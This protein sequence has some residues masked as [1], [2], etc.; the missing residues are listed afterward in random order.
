MNNRRIILLASAAFICAP[1]ITFGQLARKVHRIGFLAAGAP[2]GAY[3]AQLL[4][5]FRAGMRELGYV[6]GQTFA[7][8]A[9]Y[10][11]GHFERFPAL[12]AELVQMKVD[13]LVTAGGT[14]AVRAAQEA[15]RAIPIVAGSI[16]DPVASGLVASLARPGGNITGLTNFQIDLGPKQLELLATAVP[17]L[18]RIAVLVNPD[19]AIT[20]A[21]ANNIASAARKLGAE[22]QQA[23]AR[24]AEE[25]DK[26]FA[27]I[28]SER[29]GACIIASDTFINTEFRR[30]AGLAAKNRLPCIGPYREYAEA[31]GLMSYGQNVIESYRR[32][33]S[34]VDKILKG[35]K[36]GDLPIEQP[37]RLDLVINLKTAKALGIT[38]PNSILVRA[39]KVIE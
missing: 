34:Y 37:T 21:V 9:R 22:V 33:A 38:I 14:P 4:E 10:A 25:I 27:T 24:S 8:E 11:D 12:V 26:A 36:P 31:G 29:A 35:T 17:K 18:S 19:N 23:K 1:R 20:G 32:V 28:A 2:S 6:E 15:T 13:V 7:I 16:A 5:A 39:D 3:H 30:I